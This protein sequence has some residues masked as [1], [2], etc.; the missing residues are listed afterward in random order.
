MW[1]FFTYGM[2]F[3]TLYFWHDLLLQ[4]GQLL[5]GLDNPYFCLYHT[6]FPMYN[7]LCLSLNVQQDTLLQL[8]FGGI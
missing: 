7:H 8:L 5:S 6:Y 3:P 4:W 2:F 1:V